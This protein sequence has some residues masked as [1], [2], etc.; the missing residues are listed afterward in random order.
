[1]ALEAPGLEMVRFDTIFNKKV[2]GLGEGAHVHLSN[3]I[4]GHDKVSIE[5]SPVHL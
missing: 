4:I 1:M 2:I 3:A 5:L